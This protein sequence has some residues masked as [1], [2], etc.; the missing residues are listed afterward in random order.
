MEF[1]LKSGI[2]FTIALQNIGDWL[3]PIM[4]GFTFL[5]TEEFF[6]VFLVLIWAID[7]H[8]SLRLGIMLMLTSGLNSFFKMAHHQPRPYW[9][10][11]KVQ[12]LGGLEK[13]FGLPSG[14]SQ[15]P[16]SVYGL[17]AS[18]MKE[19]W[20]KIL[21]WGIVILIGIS[22]MI[23]G[24][25]FYV[26]V[27]VG[28]AIGLI[29]LWLYLRFEPAVQSWFSKRE[30]GGKV[31]AVFLLSLVLLIANFGIR[32][33]NSDITLDPAW[34]TNSSAAHPGEEIDP[35]S[36]DSPITSA[37]AL[38]GLAVGYFWITKDGNY[39]AEKSIAKRILIFL[40]GLV[41]VLVI[42]EGLGAIFPRSD[43]LLGY[44]FRY[45]RYTLIGFW[46]MGMGPWLLIK[47]K[48]AKK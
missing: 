27:I 21:I 33:L 25:H 40:I 14:H 6:I 23:L 16:V 41:G 42:K 38:F 28:W 48:L 24:M 34:L 19:Q 5:G 29:I 30:F 1:F 7:Y 35:Y 12:G 3:F 4:K 37:A 26:D 17:L 9:Y 46:I 2:D 20:S 43:D 15:T 8:F 36:M 18:K 11:S 47:L 10:S 13:S 31:L 22:R 45:L 39:Q 32:T 44:F